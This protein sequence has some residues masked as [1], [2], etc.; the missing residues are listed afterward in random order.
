MTLFARPDSDIS[1]GSWSTTPLWSKLDDNSDVDFVQ[2]PPDPVG[3]T[4]EVSLT[5]VVDPLMSTGHI[6]RA[7][8]QGDVSGT[9]ANCDVNLYQGATLIAGFS[10]VPATSFTT[11][12]YT[13]S[14]SE[15]NSITDYT[16]LRIKVTANDDGSLINDRMFCAWVEFEVPE[17]TPV[18]NSLAHNWE[19]LTEVRQSA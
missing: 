7:R 14:A 19:G 8:L 2:S 3:V 5:D 12:S 1:T 6:I 17:Q 11:Y 18:S 4:F 13:L 9:T 15:A 10:V 16:D